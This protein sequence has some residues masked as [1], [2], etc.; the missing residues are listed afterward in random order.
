[1]KTLPIPE[2]IAAA[3]GVLAADTLRRGAAGDSPAWY[4]AAIGVVGVV[5]LAWGV[6]RSASVGVPFIVMTVLFFSGL[7]LLLTAF[8]G[9]LAYGII[10]VAAVVYAAVYRHTSDRHPGATAEPAPA[11]T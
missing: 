11:Q 5:L 1:M 9:T 3:L 10:L 8:H 6:R 4:A 2:L 7:A